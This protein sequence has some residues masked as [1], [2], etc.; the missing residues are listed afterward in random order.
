MDKFKLTV[1]LVPKSCHY[2]NVRSE[3]S[4]KEWDKIRKHCYAL[5]NNKCEICGGKGKKHPVECHEVWDY[6]EGV[7]TLVRMI[8]LCPP[9]HEVKHLGLAQLRGNLKRA[10][11]H[12]CKVNKCNE[13]TAY[14]YFAEVFD[15]WAERSRQDWALDISYLDNL[16]TE[17]KT[18]FKISNK[19]MPKEES[20]VKH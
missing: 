17:E 6:A 3:V 19:D 13:E 5:A 4:R 9:C 7:Q 15:E 2:S 18:D 16:F 11:N 1:E 10:T 14:R 8:S 20:N 12:F